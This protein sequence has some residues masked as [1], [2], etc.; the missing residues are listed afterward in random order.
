[1]RIGGNRLLKELVSNYENELVSLEIVP[2]NRKLEEVVEWYRRL[3]RRVIEDNMTFVVQ[4]D[5]NPPKLI[6][7]P[8]P[9][10]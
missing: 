3:L 2:R 8:E 6:V 4:E 1:M 7:H 10:M 9:L 5:M